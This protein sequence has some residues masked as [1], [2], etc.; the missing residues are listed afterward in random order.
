MQV[1]LE[2][3]FRGIDS[4]PDIEDRIDE[5][6]NNL[7]R[8]SDR[9][10]SIRVAVEKP[11]EHQES[12]SP[13]RVRID[14]THPPGHEL[15]ARR[16]PGEGDIHEPLLAVLDDA[17]EAARKQLR[18]LVEKQQGKVKEHPQQAVN[19]FV[20]KIFQARGY[21]FL[22]ATDGKEVYFHRNSVLGDGF[23][24]LKEGAGVHYTEEMGE[25]GPQA[26]SVR[27]IEMAGL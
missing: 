2:L 3:S 16:E 14:I 8:V 4:S 19:A 11:Q 13:Y 15:V 21:G 25:K 9:I 22:K 5:W 6:I 26:S 17:F 10:G 12:G 18:T 1:P 23:E 7:E 27:I 20:E 24:R